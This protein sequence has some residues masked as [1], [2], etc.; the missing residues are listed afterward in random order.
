MGESVASKTHLVRRAWLRHPL[1]E[2]RE[3]EVALKLSETAG[4]IRG[5]GGPNRSGGRGAPVTLGASGRRCV[6]FV[7]FVTLA[8]LQ[9]SAPGRGEQG[10]AISECIS[11]LAAHARCCRREGDRSARC[12]GDNEG[13]SFSSVPLVRATCA[14][15]A[16]EKEQASFSCAVAI[17]SSDASTGDVL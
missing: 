10:I 7:S 6:R 13:D 16:R 11:R 17:G 1:A 5:I 4:F 14:A 15:W 9:G 2:S 8:R 12:E 3:E